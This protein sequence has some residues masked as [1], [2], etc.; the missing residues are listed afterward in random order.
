MCYNP[1]PSPFFNAFPWR[2][3]GLDHLTEEIVYYCCYYALVSILRFTLFYYV[4]CKPYFLGP[5]IFKLCPIILT[6][7]KL[8]MLIF[9]MLRWVHRKL[10][11]NGMFRVYSLFFSPT[12]PTSVLYWDI[13]FKDKQW[14]H[15]SV[16]KPNKCSLLW[17]YHCCYVAQ[18]LKS[19]HS[20]NA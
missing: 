15:D 2:V 17:K 4:L 16:P 14:A 1:F 12:C 20:E 11:S 18:Q 13:G 5:C 3:V 9:C 7:W 6:H 19:F 8:N 10:M